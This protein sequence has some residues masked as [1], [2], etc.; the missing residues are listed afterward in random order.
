MPFE[1]ERYRVGG[2]P[3]E[4]EYDCIVVGAGISGLAAAHY[5]RARF[6]DRCAH[7]RPRQSRR[8]WRSCAPQRVPGRRPAAD[9][10][11]RQRSTAIAGDEFFADGECPH[12][13]ARRRDRALPHVLRS[14][15]VSRARSVARQLLRP[16]AIRHRPARHRRPHRLGGRRHPSG[17]A[18]WPADRGLHRRFSNLS[19][20]APP[21]RRV[22]HEQARRPGEASR[23]RGTRGL[24]LEDL[25]CGV[26]ASRLG[27][28]RRG[29]RVLRWSDLRLLR[30]AAPPASGT[31]LR[32]LCVSGICGHRDAGIRGGRRRAGRALHLS[33]PRRE[34]LD[35][36]AAG[37][38]T[39]ARGDAGA[40][41]GRHRARGGPLRGARPAGQPRADPPHEH[42]GPHRKRRWTWSRSA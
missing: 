12:A 27:S 42:G 25:L 30:A 19:G 9:R 31:G 7:P 11:W 13:R 41:H 18:Q 34:R 26:P 16:R 14:A 22:V 3:V 1:G 6:G 2:L 21:A 38:E 23:R 5:Y 36:A 8:I 4:E 28:V 35:R 10:L 40:E 20:L 32:A 15:A 29:D 37:A 33:L 24:S 39:R 17:S